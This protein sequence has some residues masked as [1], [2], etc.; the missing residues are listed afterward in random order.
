MAL[1]PTA[2]P[3]DCPAGCSLLARV[4]EGKVIEITGDP[5]NP[6]TKG[7][8]CGKIRRQPESMYHPD[9][10]TQPMRRVGPKG[11]GTFSPIT[12]TEATEEITARWKALMAEGKAHSILPY[13]FAG[14]MGCINRNCGTAFFHALGASRLERTICSS[15]TDAAWTSIMGS[16]CD[17]SQED[18]EYSDF[19]L[20]WGVNLPATRI[21]NLSIMER[22]RTAEKK[23]ILID[24]YENPSAGCATE[25]LLIR[26]GTDGALALAM[27]HVLDREGLTNSRYLSANTTGWPALQA[28]LSQ[29]TPEWAASVT[30]LSAE[31]IHLLA[32]QYGR[33]NAPV[34]HMGGGLARRR[35][36]AENARAIFC[37][38]AA[39]GAW[40]KRGGGIFGVATAPPLVDLTA[41]RRPDWIDPATPVINMNQ[42]GQALEGDSIRSLY[43]Y[44]A[45]PAA[46]APDQNAVLRGLARTD[47]FTVVHE[48]FMT[49]TARYAD[50]LLPA[51]Y[52][53]ETED[54]YTPYGCASIQYVKPVAPPYKQ[55]KGN[56]EVFQILAA[57]MELMDPFFSQTP[58]QL[59]RSMVTGSP[60]LTAEEK[61]RV[62]AGDPVF[63]KKP[64][65]LPINTSNHKIHLADPQPPRWLPPIQEGTLCLVTAPA[66]HS[67]NSSFHEVDS[68]KSLRGK[69]T[70]HMNNEDAAS[71]GIAHGDSVVA[72]NE[73]GQADFIAALDKAVAPGTVVA[74]GVFPGKHTVNALTHQ[75][76]SDMG[77]ASTFNDNPVEVRKAY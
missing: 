33:A 30:G 76:L 32:L 58:A 49:D 44:H 53:T 60:H 5:S 35:N 38:P 16:S 7:L 34:I 74:E 15:A 31:R 25:T 28:T 77:R 6:V 45:N 39:V 19:I 11:S 43:V 47:L 36:G 20:L 2:C 40:R 24:V 50:I 46:A 64:F 1:F 12:W 41:V 57:A 59:C 48:R 37:L 14:T 63:P 62:L 42:L 67:L 66:I 71:R 56:W 72:F 9:R 52:M 18:L 70:L 8:V 65:P 17:L 69:P 68:M 21:H 51:A 54:L 61:S 3:Y 26:P 13:S 27:L 73:L 22:A 23:V 29:Y 75:R 55:C 10:L 4:E